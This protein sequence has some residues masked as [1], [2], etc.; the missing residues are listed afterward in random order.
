MAKG[1]GFKA[2]V[3]TTEQ[4]DIIVSVKAFSG[5]VEPYPNLAPSAKNNWAKP[6]GTSLAFR[7]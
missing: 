1:D 7:N 4:E 5:V 6:T 2:W 3:E